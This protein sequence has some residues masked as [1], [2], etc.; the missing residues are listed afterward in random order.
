M[1]IINFPRTCLSKQKTKNP[2]KQRTDQQICKSQ[3]LYSD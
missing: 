3:G 1:F 2:E